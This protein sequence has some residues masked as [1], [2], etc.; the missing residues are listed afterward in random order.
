MRTIKYTNKNHASITFPTDASII[1]DE[2]EGLDG[3]SVELTTT[4]FYRQHGTTHRYSQLVERDIV[5][6]FS[7]DA[8]NHADY[9]NLRSKIMGTFLPL[10]TGR[11][12]IRDEIH[13][14]YC[15][16]YVSKAPAIEYWD[17]ATTASGELTLT[18][19][20]PILWDID[21]QERELIT[22]TGGWKWPW[23]GKFKLKQRGTTTCTVTND[24]QLPVPLTVQFLGPCLNPRITNLTTGEYIQ[25]NDTIGTGETLII[26]T[27]QHDKR[28]VIK[29]NSGTRSGENLLADASTFFQLEV[30]ANRLAY[31]TGGDSPG[32]VVVGWRRGYYG[33]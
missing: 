22:W 24:G 20:D 13:H 33:I 4:Q 7:I 26:T 15:D 10:G 12:E 25:I 3:Q 5:I 9:M 1:A 16:C 31:S 21:D 6:P 14:V 23:T 29:T 27:G 19:P 2:I 8:R 17:G 28:A 32:G 18:A 11:L 30:G